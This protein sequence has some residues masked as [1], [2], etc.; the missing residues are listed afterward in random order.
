VSASQAPA[1]SCETEQPEW[2]VGSCSWPSGGRRQCCSQL[3]AGGLLREVRCPSITHLPWCARREL[4][5]IGSPPHPIQGQDLRSAG[6]SRPPWAVAERRFCAGPP[7]AGEGS[8]GGFT[9]VAA[10]G[11]RR[12]SQRVRG[13]GLAG[14]SWLV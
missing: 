3:P 4:T 10:V 13:F 8:P 9:L 12:I 11:R 5:K 14:V 7:K 1:K 6:G 2:V